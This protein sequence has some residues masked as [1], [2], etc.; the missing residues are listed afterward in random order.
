MKNLNNLPL[1]LRYLYPE[2]LNLGYSE[3]LCKIFL[4]NTLKECLN[5]KPSKVHTLVRLLN[6]G[7]N[8]TVMCIDD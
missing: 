2:G 5:T 8:S 3:I 1:D 4:H 6:T 7:H